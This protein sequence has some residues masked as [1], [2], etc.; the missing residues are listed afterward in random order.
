MLP[1]SNETYLKSLAFPATFF[2]GALL[3]ASLMPFGFISQ[4]PNEINLT[5]S[6]SA[7]SISSLFGTDELGRSI[8]SRVVAGA[9]ISLLAAFGAQSISFFIGMSIGTVAGYY[10]HRWQ[11]KCFL[12]IMSCFHGFPFLLFVLAITAALGPGI[13]KT[14]FAIGIVNWVG[15]AR[16]IRGE[17]ISH[18]ERAYVLTGRAFGFSNFR[19]MFHHILPNV[20]PI[21][22]GI[23]IL[24]FGD[25]VAVEAGL[26]FLGLGVQPPDASWGKMI[27]TGKDYL[28]TAWWM[29]VFPGIFLVTTILS[30]NIIGEHFERR[31][32]R[33]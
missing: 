19:V 20:I 1:F 15:I 14:I 8:L 18:S 30:L 29:S 2:L 28:T 13:Y 25:V 7:P 32:R 27:F 26:S 21:S 33:Q 23:I 3:T 12:Y 6:L 11:D 24:G 4:G 5:N 9:R 10:K 22:M 16:V 17:V 31:F